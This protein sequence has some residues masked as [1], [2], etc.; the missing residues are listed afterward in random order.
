VLDAGVVDQYVDSAEERLRPR[1]HRFDLLGLAHVGVAE[2]DL[3]VVAL[4]RRSNA[5]V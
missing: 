4:G 3:N 5:V 1:H 2:R